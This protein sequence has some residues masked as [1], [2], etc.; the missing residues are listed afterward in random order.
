M[1]NRYH[2]Y[3]GIAFGV[4]ALAIGLLILQSAKTVI[5]LGEDPEIPVPSYV[6]YPSSDGLSYLP[7]TEVE[8]AVF[9]RLNWLY[10]FGVLA[11]LITF[12]RILKRKE[13]HTLIDVVIAFVVACLP[14]FLRDG[15]F[16]HLLLIANMLY[17]PFHNRLVVTSMSYVFDNYTKAIL[18]L[19][20]FAGLL[21]CV[22]HLRLFSCRQ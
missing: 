2:R 9:I 10:F 3:I 19:I 21:L 6:Y 17:A 15:I 16:P 13:W 12:V 4:F 8:L 20:L 1:K 18:W 22:N 11:V 7:I 14:S 5:Y